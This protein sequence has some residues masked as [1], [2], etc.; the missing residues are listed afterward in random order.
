V[1][2]T[3]IAG[4]PVSP[5]LNRWFPNPNV[6]ISF[7]EKYRE[8]YRT[9]YGAIKNW[10]QIPLEAT[11]QGRILNG[12]LG[13]IF[14]LTPLT[15]LSLR[16]P[17]GRRALPA[18]LLLGSTYTG[19]LGTRFLLSAL[20]FLSLSLALVL[21]R[22]RTGLPAVVFHAV[23]SW[24][25]V[26][27]VTADPYAWRLDRFRWKQAWRL[28]PE[29]SFLSRAIDAY[30]MA[31]MIE[32]KVPAGAR[33]FTFGGV[34]EA[35]T[36]RDIA[37]AYQSGLNNALGEILASGIATD[38]VAATA[39]EFRIAPRNVRRVRLVQ[40]ATTPQIWSVSELR[41]LSPAGKEYPRAQWWRISAAPNPWDV[42]WAFDD[43]PVTRWKVWQEAV[44]GQHIEIDF[45]RPVEL[46]GLRVEMSSDQPA[47]RTRVEGETTPGGWEVLAADPASSI[48][49]PPPPQVRRIAT[50]DVKRLGFSHLVVAKDEFLAADLFRNESAWGLTRIGETRH[51]RLYRIN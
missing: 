31:K 42:Q 15:L 28:E 8:D 25:G 41:V 26:A 22:W 20:P 7:E 45:V 39:L 6:R 11:V 51:G 21:E 4:N 13:H 5:F 24:P 44:P 46:G 14:L 17:L 16:W 1:K 30:P 29:E 27:A 19:N 34:A 37:I 32:E 12:Y 48:P 47:I 23:L 49:I 50:N 35:Y 33:V 2:N 40:T 3:L 18:A 10:T 38:M 43:C 9:I 36:S